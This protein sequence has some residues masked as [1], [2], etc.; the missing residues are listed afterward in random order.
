MCSDHAPAVEIPAVNGT[1]G[2]T[3]GRR[4]PKLPYQQHHSDE[5]SNTGRFQII[6]STLREGEQFANAFYD[7]GTASKPQMTRYSGTND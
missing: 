5:R 6:E 7:T 1:N 4:Q 3:N 2:V